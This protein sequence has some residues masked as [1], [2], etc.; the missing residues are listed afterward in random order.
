MD[1]LVRTSDSTVSRY[2]ALGG[3]L[4]A[5]WTGTMA[6]QNKQGVRH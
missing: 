1:S 3:P 2:G 4:L 5:H 6:P